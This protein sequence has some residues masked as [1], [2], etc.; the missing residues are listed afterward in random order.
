[1]KEKI[2]LA[3]SGGADSTFAAILLQ[4]MGY[5]VIAFNFPIAKRVSEDVYNTAKRLGIKLEIID[6]RNIFDAVIKENFYNSYLQG[7]TPNPCVRCNRYIKFGVLYNIIKHKYKIDKMATGHYAKIFKDESIGEESFKY[8]IMKGKDIQKD[9]SYFLWQIHQSI[10]KDII[11]PLGIYTKAEVKDILLKEGFENIA[12]REESYDICFINQDSYKNYINRFGL[13]E[14]DLQGNFLDENGNILGKHSGIYRYTVGQRKGLNIAF[15]KRVYVRKID[16]LNKSVVLGEKPFIRSLKASNI[17]LF[18]PSEKISE[19][20]EYFVKI[21]YKSKEERA[22]IKLI[23]ENN[24]KKLLIEFY[25]QAE[26]SSCGQSA[27]VYDKDKI[28]AGGIIEGYDL[29]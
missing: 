29:I 14:L 16:R 23:I 1:M 20:D 4:N 7:L 19:S 24:T 21:R 18:L 12:K 28:I 10:L 9:Q 3:F 5:E 17:N 6:I 13:N 25:T 22:K 8:F 26:A 27:V 11:F 15:G 2:G